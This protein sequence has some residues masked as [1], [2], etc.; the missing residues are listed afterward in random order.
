MHTALVELRKTRAVL[1]LGSGAGGSMSLITHGFFF[2]RTLM[3]KKVP[4][5]WILYSSCSKSSYLTLELLAEGSELQLNL[6]F[7]DLEY[8]MK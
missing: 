2:Y 8:A 7:G 3:D 6:R 5:I 4:P 1:Q